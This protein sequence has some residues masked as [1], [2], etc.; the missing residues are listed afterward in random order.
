MK[1]LFKFLF[2]GVFGLLWIVVAAMAL[3]VYARREAK[4]AQ[5]GCDRYLEERRAAALPEE[6]RVL[7][8]H[9]DTDA[10][11]Q[12]PLR[13][14]FA[15]LDE[16]HRQ[17]LVESRSELVAITGWDGA[18]K[19]IYCPG[20]PS[21][22]AALAEALRGKP[23]L[24]A[25]LNG[26]EPSTPL[27]EIE[28]S[29]HNRCRQLINKEFK[30]PGIGKCLY[31]IELLPCGEDA[32]FFIRPS[33]YSQFNVAFRK[34]VCCTDTFEFHECE[35]F[36]TNSLG[37]RSAEVAVPKPPGIVRIACIGG[38]TTAEGRTNALTYPHMLEAKLRAAFGT[39]R[40][41]V[42]NCGVHGMTSSDEDGRGKDYAALEPDIVIHY[43]LINDIRTL[44]LRWSAAAP[45][46]AGPG[47]IYPRLL[48]STF[49]RLYCSYWLAP[50]PGSLKSNYEETVFQPLHRVLDKLQA[51]GAKICLC[52]FA[53]P[54]PGNDRREKVF[55]EAAL[56]D[57]M[58]RMPAP[59]FAGYVKCTDF[60]NRRFKTMCAESGWNYVPVAE[61]L[62]SGSEHFI[63]ICHLN[64]QGIE[65]KADII[66]ASVKDLVA[67]TL[68]ERRAEPAGR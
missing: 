10:C 47:S 16:P 68:E 64:P 8:A 35:N 2:L 51:Q 4:A 9:P 41:E 45:L 1:R 22:V 24:L 49:I 12:Q 25:V 46:F 30:V 36:R 15:G 58:Y 53:Y 60:C 59:N 3:E 27:V 67:K 38:S 54:H 42:V 31:Q 33:I 34:S 11:P 44:M 61:E 56:H 26:M 14:T 20:R 21:E 43:N 13:N 19:Q 48:D 17:D 5:E 57:F 18:I 28:Q 7:L 29:M 52:S 66:F 62:R 6:Q 50:A 39:D 37:W 65:R 23:N 63:D 32:G 55:F 40:I